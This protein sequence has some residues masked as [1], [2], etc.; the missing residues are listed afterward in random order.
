MNTR[1]PREIVELIRECVR[2]LQGIVPGSTIQ[3]S[4]TMP[5]P[6]QPH[7]QRRPTRS[8]LR[9]RRRQR[10]Q[11]QQRQQ[12]QQQAE[13]HQCEC[14]FRQGVAS[15]EQFLTQ[16]AQA[17]EAP[18]H[19]RPAPPCVSGYDCHDVFCHHLTPGAQAIRHGL[20]SLGSI[21]TT[22][23]AGP[24]CQDSFW[25]GGASDEQFHSQ[26]QQQPRR[27]QQRRR[28]PTRRSTY[29]FNRDRRREW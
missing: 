26:Q 22:C 24:T 25:Q 20:A 17:Q 8:Q 7:E 27:H 13:D 15:D 2:A 28:R 11:R 6:Q 14:S 18:H 4:I 10:Q 1:T 5:T 9:N 23:N 3:I 12:Q 19:E 29:G 16:E 21:T